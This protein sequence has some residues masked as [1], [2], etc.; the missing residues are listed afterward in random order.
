M[1]FHVENYDHETIFSLMVHEDTITGQTLK[2]YLR[3]MTPL[4][5]LPVLSPFDFSEFDVMGSQEWL[6]WYGDN[7]NIFLEMKGEN[8]VPEGNGYFESVVQEAILLIKN[9]MNYSQ[10]EL[11]S[12]METHLIVLNRF[13]VMFTLKG[14]YNRMIVFS[15]G[16]GFAR[17]IAR[18]MMND[19]ISTSEFDQMVKAA[20]AEVGNMIVGLSLKH[21][22]PL[23]D[24]KM[25]TPMCFE[26][27]QG[28]LIG[29]SKPVSVAVC[30]S[31]GEAFKV[32][33]VNFI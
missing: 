5:Q 24:V 29:A 9:R 20:V 26:V 1:H 12:V 7:R 11:M 30:S 6:T 3:S 19:N 31:C 25:S 10:F 4:Q 32:Y 23:G 17:E 28:H 13:N 21:I 22:L 16:D 14:D 15:I 2:S 8:T 27:S 33:G 18:K